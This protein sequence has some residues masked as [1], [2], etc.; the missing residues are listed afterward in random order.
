MKRKVKKFRVGGETEYNEEDVGLFGGKIKYR[1][2]PATGNKYV[3][4]KANPFDRN[5]A[6]QRYYSVNDVKS[7]LGMGSKEDSKPTETY[8]DKQMKRYADMPDV[9]NVTPEVPK[10]IASGFKS[11]QSVF[12]RQDNEVKLPKAVSISKERTTVTAPNLA[13][14]K[15]G[16]GYE[17]VSR[18]LRGS[19]KVGKGYEGLDVRDKSAKN[20]STDGLG[21]AAAVLAG[22]GGLGLAGMKGNMKRST[23]GK[24]SLRKGIKTLDPSQPDYLDEARFAD[25]GNPNF[26]RGGKVKAKAKMSYGGKVKK[27]S[28][29]GK[30][31]SASAR[32][33][34]CAIRGKTRA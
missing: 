2:D 1:T 8:I 9:Q 21:T 31:K 19:E 13:K 28:T 34:G 11:D 29:G 32:A 7:K 33:D 4:G 20:S 5:P 25:E 24:S 27:M 18:S 12:K 23:D 16:K 15:V 10:G 14:N 3:A 17:E 26:K 6:E 30:A 22:L